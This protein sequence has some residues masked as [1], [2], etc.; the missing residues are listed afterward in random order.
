MG[1]GSRTISV[2]PQVTTLDLVVPQAVDL[3]TKQKIGMSEV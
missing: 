1:E 2:L 3:Y